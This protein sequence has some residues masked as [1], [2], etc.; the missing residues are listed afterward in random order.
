MLLIGRDLTWPE[1]DRV[2]ISIS[3]YSNEP[4]LLPSGGS[5]RL[6]P[7]SGN[8]LNVEF[9][10]GGSGKVPLNGG[11]YKVFTLEGGAVEID[12]VLK[13]ISVDDPLYTAWIPL[14]DRRKVLGFWDTWYVRGPPGIDFYTLPELKNMADLMAFWFIDPH[15]TEFF[16]LM[17]KHVHSLD[18]YNISPVLRHQKERF[19]TVLGYR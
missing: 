3:Q 13:L 2:A 7:A 18:N 17:K 14:G 6:V 1:N 8:P 11:Y 16:S 9:L 5:F 4:Y 19:L 15:D 12:T 10:F